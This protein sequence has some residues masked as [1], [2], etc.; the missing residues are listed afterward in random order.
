M[1]Y[2]NVLEEREQGTGMVT[3]ARSDEFTGTE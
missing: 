3:A 1:M 2:G